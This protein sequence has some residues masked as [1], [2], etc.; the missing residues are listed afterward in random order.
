MRKILYLIIYMSLVL[1]S[2]CDVHEWPETS[3]FVKIHLRLNYET[4]MTEW[5]HLYDGASVIEQALG[6]TYDNRQDYGKIRYIIRTYPVSVK[7]RTSQ[8]YTQEFVFTKDISEGYNHE[9]TLDILSGNYNLMVWSDLIESSGD[10]YFHNAENFAE[11]MLQGDHRGNTDHRDAFRGISNIS[12]IAD[13][14]E[15]APDTID[16]VMQRPLAKFEFLTND[17]KEFID[18]EY[19]YLQKAAATRGEIPPTRVN[20]DDY[21]VVFSYS[22]YMPN[23]YSM[24]SDKPVDSKMG[25]TFES[26]IDILNENEAS[27]GFDYVFVNGKEAGVSVQIGLYDSKD[28]QIALTEPIDVSLRRSHHTILKG[29]FLMEETSGGIKINTDFDGNHNIVID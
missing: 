18:K 5:K 16:I 25:V 11:I 29:S 15:H 20:A 8:N 26:K 14:V 7:Q 12:L 13:I 1:L 21:K 9:V 17:L 22:G 28:R 10:S 2:A 24:N 19:Q 6:D 23:A 3:E 4:D 27:L